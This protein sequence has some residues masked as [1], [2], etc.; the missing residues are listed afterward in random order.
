MKALVLSSCCTGPGGQ[1]QAVRVDSKHLYSLSHLTGPQ[2]W[3]L[4]RQFTNILL[5]DTCLFAMSISVPFLH[6][7]T[8]Y[9]D[10]TL[11]CPI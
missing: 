6:L 10:K 2:R 9:L 5:I 4:A 3:L 1:T 11:P 7:R 8:E